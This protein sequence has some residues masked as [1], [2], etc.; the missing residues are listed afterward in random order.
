MDKILVDRFIELI[1]NGL[2]G[3]WVYEGIPEQFIC[4]EKP[5][6]IGGLGKLII[7]ETVDLKNPQTVEYEIIFV[8]NPNPIGHDFIYMNIYVKTSGQRI[9][10]QLVLN[11]LNS[12]V[13]AMYLVLD[14][15]FL[16]YHRLVPRKLE[17][18]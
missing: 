1:E 15:R 2:K 18:E 5:A 8:D 9:Q 7:S 17:D 16:H 11:F 6:E 4:F 14:G 13:G 12:W 3:T 10:Y